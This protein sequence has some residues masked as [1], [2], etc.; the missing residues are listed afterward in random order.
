MSPIR[1]EDIASKLHHVACFLLHFGQTDH[2]QA[3]LTPSTGESL[4]KAN[5]APHCAKSF[6]ALPKHERDSCQSTAAPTQTIRTH[7]PAFD[8]SEPMSSTQTSRSD[9][10]TS[11]T[12]FLPCM[13]RYQ[14]QSGHQT[15]R[16]CSNQAHLR[17]RI[18]LGWALRTTAF[19]ADF[20][21]SQPPP[22]CAGP[23]CTFR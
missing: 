18:Q 20:L 1:P 15:L 10:W 3:L 6:S 16:L 2:A 5:S 11:C 17:G 21:G 13:S 4:P 22:I 12:E 8:T 23:S 7:P 14:I 19:G 9:V